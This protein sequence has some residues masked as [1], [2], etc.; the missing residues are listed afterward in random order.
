MGLPAFWFWPN[1]DA[2]S[3]GISKALRVFREN[4]ENDLIHFV[5][6]MSPEDFLKLATNSACVVGNSSVAIRECS[7][8][9]IPAVNIGT[10][11]IGRER[12]ANVIDVSH[13]SS[14]IYDAIKQQI[15]HGYFNSDNLYGDGT[16]G[17]K[18][19]NILYNC[20]LTIQKHFFDTHLQI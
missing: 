4:H 17:E 8:L 7:F 16:A 2:G 3:G 19:A 12:G 9:G 5:R 15:N 10:R 13:E 6:N 18:T 1:P 11:Q 20:D 14:E